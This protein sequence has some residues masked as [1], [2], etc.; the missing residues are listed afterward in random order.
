MQKLILAYFNKKIIIILFVSKVSWRNT[1]HYHQLS[2]SYALILA[3]GDLVGQ[4]RLWDVST[5]K[6]AAVLEAPQGNK[7][8]AGEKVD[9]KI[10]AERLFRYRR[11]PTNTEYKQIWS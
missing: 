2:A 3:S 6:C 11:P 5:G 1:Q 4:V 7:Q 9:I 8:V 10:F